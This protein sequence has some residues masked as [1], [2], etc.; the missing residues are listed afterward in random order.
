MAAKKKWK[1][2]PPLKLT[3]TVVIPKWMTADEARKIVTDAWP[4]GTPMPFDLSDGS[5]YIRHGS[6]IPRWSWHHKPL[7][8]KRPA[9]VE[10]EA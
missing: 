6:L 8:K 3:L 5:F 7:R 4:D 9:A 1:P 2:T 10:P